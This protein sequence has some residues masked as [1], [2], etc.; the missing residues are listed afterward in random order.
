M[1]EKK[2]WLCRNAQETDNM[3]Q[4]KLWYLL[5]VLP[6]SDLN[7]RLKFLMLW[8]PHS[9]EMYEMLCFLSQNRSQA[10]L[11]RS[12]LT[13]ALKFISKHL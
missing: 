11:M 13:N 9:T 10:R 8:K 5:G 2:F 12:I 7:T 1:H 4:F 6:V 3:I